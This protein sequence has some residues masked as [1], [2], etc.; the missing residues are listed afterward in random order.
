[1]RGHQALYSGCGGALSADR[2]PEDHNVPPDVTPANISA[3]FA[4]IREHVRETP[5][6][7]IAGADFGIPPA[8]LVFKLELLQHSGSFKVRGAFANLL[9]RDIPPAGVT[10]ASGGNHGVAVAFAA[11]ARGVRAKIFVPTISSPA[12]VERIRGYGAEL[13]V[14]GERY[15]DALAASEEWVA[16]S[17]S[18][19]IPAFDQTETMLGT[20][21]LGCEFER[22]A[23]A[24]DTVLVAVG[25]GG[26]IAGVAAWYQRRVRVIGVEPEASPTLFRALAA[27]RPVDAETGGIAADSLAPRRVGD[28]VFPVAQAHVDR[29]VLVSDMAIVAAQRTLWDVIRVVAEPG[30]A[31]PFAALISGAY[32]PAPGERVGV[33][34]CGANTTAVEFADP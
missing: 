18:L 29:V 3:A 23:G 25:G 22:Q 28:L 14:G 24:L 13:V 2:A 26:L 5:V 16:Q 17:G 21:T 15:A 11:R 8:R 19:P 20:G 10:A 33:V 9:L 32:V 6:V 30:A 4:R 31:A 27:G 1:M 34:V 7:A 12:K